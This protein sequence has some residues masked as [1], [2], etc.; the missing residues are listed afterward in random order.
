MGVYIY[1]YILF[2]FDKGFFPVPHTADQ[3][4]ISTPLPC[5]SP[6]LACPRISHVPPFL[7]YQCRVLLFAE[8][9]PSHAGVTGVGH[10]R[11]SNK[12][13]VTCNACSEWRRKWLNAQRVINQ[14][15]RV[16]LLYGLQIDEFLLSQCHASAKLVPYPPLCFCN[17]FRYKR[18]IWETL[19]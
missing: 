7:S 13:R 11:F 4:K 18:N 1:I 15:C 16:P 17:S 10:L 3:N 5:S 9:S 14:F 19:P 6:W 8:P 2:Y 12:T